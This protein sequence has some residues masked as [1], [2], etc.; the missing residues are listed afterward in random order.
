VLPDAASFDG[1]LRATADR[2]GLLVSDDLGAAL[3]ALAGSV[4]AILTPDL[5]IA[6]AAVPR[7]EELVRFFL[8]SEY[9]ELRAA[10]LG[11]GG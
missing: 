4:D 7:G 9:G 5:P 8:S 3:R 11:T 6:L 1:A 2:A 10:W